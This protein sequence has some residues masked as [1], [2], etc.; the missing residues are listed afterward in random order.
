MTA[1]TSTVGFLLIDSFSL[2]SFTCAMEVL[3]QSNRLASKTLYEW[4]VCSMGGEDVA[5]S[6][7]IR[8]ESRHDFL[9]APDPDLLLIVSASARPLEQEVL[10]HRRL[11][12]LAS[13]GARLGAVTFG[14]Y[15]LARAGLL[16]GHRCTVHWENLEAF[17]ET[18]PRLEVTGDLYEMDGERYTCSGGTAAMDMMLRLVALE[19]GEEFAC[20]VADQFLHQRIR[21]R[22]EHQRMPLRARIGVS[23]PKLLRYV[24]LL[25]SDGDMRLSQRE[26]AQRVG[27]SSRQLE[28]LFRKYLGTTP[29]RYSMDH[30]LQRARSLLRDTSMSIIEVAV[31]CGFASHSHFSKSYRDRFGTTPRDERGHL[32]PTSLH[33]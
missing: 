19:H 6:A 13:R 9:S 17:R 24:E 29:S 20:T 32:R 22:Q 2:M 12:Y 4:Y 16:D 25:E 10:V 11:R 33:E 3:R 28:R 18:F 15:V 8:I 1:R 30:R 31:V 23:H 7:G 5:C 21:G 27:L 14:A 26:L